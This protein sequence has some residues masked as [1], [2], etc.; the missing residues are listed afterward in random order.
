MN[1]VEQKRMNGVEQSPR[2]QPGSVKMGS[3]PLQNLD[4]AIVGLRRRSAATSPKGVDLARI[5][6]SGYFSE[7]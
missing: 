1:G 3:A 7:L 5:R 2:I 4:K 6:F